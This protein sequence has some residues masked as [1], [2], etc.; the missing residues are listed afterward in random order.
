MSE[1]NFQFGVNEAESKNSAILLILVEGFK[2]L[3]SRDQVKL[4]KPTKNKYQGQNEAKMQTVLTSFDQR[5][6]TPL[7]TYTLLMHSSNYAH[8][9]IRVLYMYTI[10]KKEDDYR[11][12]KI[13]ITNIGKSKYFFYFEN[14][15]IKAEKMVLKILKIQF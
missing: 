12:Q 4:R 2:V 15:K 7:N 11:C 13:N 14:K 1:G 6:N 8:Y 9:N 3:G 10:I 5:A